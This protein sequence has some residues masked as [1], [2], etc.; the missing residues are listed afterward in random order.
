MLA[1]G[2]CGKT[3]ARMSFS[4]HG[5]DDSRVVVVIMALSSLAFY[6]MAFRVPVVC[7]FSKS[8]DIAD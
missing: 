2:L 7:L 5:T 6:G 1:I 4:E 3:R 8:L